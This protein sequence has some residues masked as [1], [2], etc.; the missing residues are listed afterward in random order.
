QMT[1]YE[2]ETLLEFR[3]V[4]FRSSLTIAVLVTI[5]NSYFSALTA[6]S[7]WAYNF[8]GKTFIFGFSLLLMM[9]P[10]QLSMLGQY[11]LA[12]TL[13]ILRSEERRVGKSVD[14]CGGVDDR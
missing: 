6:F 9:V 10:G 1:A 7:F 8:K 3:R 13:G 11:E 2:V 5:L 12:S 4:L 14:L